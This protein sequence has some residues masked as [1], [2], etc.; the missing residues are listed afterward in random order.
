MQR[1][2][3]SVDYHSQQLR[4]DLLPK[5]REMLALFTERYH[6]ADADTR[7]FYS[8]FLEFVEVWNMWLA[9]ALPS[10]VPKLIGHNEANLKPFYDHLEAKM[11]ELQDA[12]L[13]GKK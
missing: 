11:Q 2:V 10:Q 4:D 12:I 8:T 5:Y 6:L 9:G 13:R 7:A 1:F 3:K